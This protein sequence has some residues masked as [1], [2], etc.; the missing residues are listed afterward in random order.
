MNSLPH[1]LTHPW[2]VAIVWCWGCFLGWEWT[3]W[4]CHHERRALDPPL[5]YLLAGESV[6]ANTHRCLHQE[7]RLAAYSFRTGRAPHK[8]PSRPFLCWCSRNITWFSNLY[9]FL[10]VRLYPALTK[11]RKNLQNILTMLVLVRCLIDVD[12]SKQEKRDQLLCQAT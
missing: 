10:Q 9:I 2:W 12:T 8:S 4:I 11:L 1:S 7:R 6:K 3:A 5:D